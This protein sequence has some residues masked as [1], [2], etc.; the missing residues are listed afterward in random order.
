VTS[1]RLLDEAGGRMAS[2][3]SPRSLRGSLI[4]LPLRSQGAGYI[5]APGCQFTDAVKMKA[6]G[7]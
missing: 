1:G 2:P 7:S 6:L 3:R 4:R 5:D